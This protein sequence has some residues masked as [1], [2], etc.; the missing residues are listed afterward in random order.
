MSNLKSYS[1]WDV[2]V[3]WFHGINLLCVIADLNWYLNT[4]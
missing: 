1:V 4:Q 3:R 2:N